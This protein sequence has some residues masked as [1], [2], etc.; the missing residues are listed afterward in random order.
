MKYS[1]LFASAM[2]L[3]TAQA[4]DEQTIKNKITGYAQQCATELGYGTEVAAIAS[5]EVVPK[6]DQERCCLECVYKKIGLL[7]S[8][9][10]ISESGAKALTK[11]R[12][13]DDAEKLAKFETVYN[14][15]KGEATV[16]S[17][18]ADKCQVASKIRA[19]VLKHKSELPKLFNKES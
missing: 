9:G 5:S 12:F 7:T 18:S 15:C 4:V 2:L 3:V 17:T 14:S 1:I 13:G 16:D 6:N 10:E 19:C 8:E 11:E